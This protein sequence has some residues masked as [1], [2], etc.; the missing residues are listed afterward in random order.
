MLDECS[1]ID[2][3]TRE[4]LS[5]ELL[6]SAPAIAMALCHNLEEGF[7]FYND[8]PQLLLALQS[9]I[10][11]FCLDRKAG[12]EK[13]LKVLSSSSSSGAVRSPSS[14]AEKIK[15]LPKDLRFSVRSSHQELVI[16]SV[17]RPQILPDTNSSTRTSLFQIGLIIGLEFNKL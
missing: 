4:A 15:K 17:K 9:K 1:G 13:L 14:P 11:S 8:L 16:R 6:I 7:E 10:S 2:P 12:K 3:P 5:K